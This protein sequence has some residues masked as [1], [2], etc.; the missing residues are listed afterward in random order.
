MLTMIRKSPGLF[1][2]FAVLVLAMGAV[3]ACSDTVEPEEEPEVAT[4]RLI[5]G[6]QTVNVNAA[7]GA[8]TGGPV[9]IPVGNTTVRAEFFLSNGQPEPLVT[10]SLFRLDVSPA[11]TALV[12]FARTGAFS[13]T[14][15]GLV[16]GQSTAV[17]FELFHLEENHGE[18]D[19]PVTVTVQ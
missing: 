15:S 1:V 5:F 8:V 2:R 7:T 14:L 11:N 18:F 13:G 9:V 3:T 10:A 4:M 6:N 19:W 12:T 16:S 17:T